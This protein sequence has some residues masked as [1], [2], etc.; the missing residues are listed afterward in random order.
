MSLPTESQWARYS[1]LCARLQPLPPPERAAALQAL[2]AQA[3]ADPQVLSL[4]AVHYALPPDPDRDRT[5]ERLGSCTLEAPL[6]VGGMGLVYRAQQHLGLTTRPVAVKLIHPTLLRTAREEALA[7]FQAEMGTLV[8]LEHEGIAQIYD[9]GIGED[10]HT[11]EQ[12]PYL[13]M[14]LI[15][16]GL[17]ITTYVQDYALPWQERLSLFVRVCQAVRYAHEHRVV[18]RDLKPTN[19]LVDSEGRPVVIDFGLASACDVL[20]P[21]A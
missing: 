10:P 21:G 17:P 9:G 5:G 6:G 13:A 8:K 7:R 2:W 19:I 16:D 3:D 20:L 12:L 18:H 1:A 11:H 14:E 4:V 15:R